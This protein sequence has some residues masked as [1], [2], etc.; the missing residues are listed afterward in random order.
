MKVKGAMPRS[1][2]SKVPRVPVDGAEL[3]KQSG[4][5]LRERN[6][7]MRAKRLKAEM[8]LAQ[9]RDQLIDKDLV[10]RQAAYLLIAFR[11]AV[12]RLPQ[13]LRSKWGPEVMTLERIFQA[14]ELITRMLEQMADLPN[15]VEPSWLKKLKEEE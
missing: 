6:A 13:E 1:R 2:L 12:L 8:E 10:G 4:I 9:T 15:C 5:Y 7:A 11:Q 3:E 14:K